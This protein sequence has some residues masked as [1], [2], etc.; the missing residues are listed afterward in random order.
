ML[1]PDVTSSRMRRCDTT[2][3]RRHR[4]GL[5]GRPPRMMMAMSLRLSHLTVVLER[6]AQ[7]R[8]LE[9]SGRR[10]AR[11]TFVTEGGVCISSCSG[12]GW[13]WAVGHIRGTMEPITNKRLSNRTELATRKPQ[14]SN[15]SA[16]EDPT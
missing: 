9:E 5:R 1:A 3:T 13:A 16:K 14:R 8:A 15:L 7:Q 10:R 11:P 6:S 4:I 12:V 2:P